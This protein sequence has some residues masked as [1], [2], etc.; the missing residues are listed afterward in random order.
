MKLQF[1]ITPI[2]SLS[3]D[4]IELFDCYQK[5]GLKRLLELRSQGLNLLPLS[6]RI[7]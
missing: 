4:W 3:F 5:A 7:R 2:Q 6:L 1:E